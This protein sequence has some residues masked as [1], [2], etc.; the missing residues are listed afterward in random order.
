MRGTLREVIEHFT[1]SE[2]LGEI[3]I[4][5]EGANEDDV[6][7]QVESVSKKKQTRNNEPDNFN[8]LIMGNGKSKNKYK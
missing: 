1:K 6:T 2:P 7:A 3:V 4:I 8:P 5:L